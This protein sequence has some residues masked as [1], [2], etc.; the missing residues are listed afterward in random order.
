MPLSAFIRSIFSRELTYLILWAVFLG[1][2][3]TGSKACFS[4]EWACVLGDMAF[5]ERRGIFSSAKYAAELVSCL[6]RHVRVG[7]KG[8]HSGYL[9]YFAKYW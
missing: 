3:S 1:L 6:E 7:I 8:M 9:R 4:S 2:S 5:K